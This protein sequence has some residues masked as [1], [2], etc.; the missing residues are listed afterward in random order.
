MG[1][2]HRI[3]ALG[4]GLI[5]V[6]ACSA[7]RGQTAAS[8]GGSTTAAPVGSP[9]SRQSSQ[10]FGTLASPCGPGHATGATDQGVTGTAIDIAYGDD[11]GF[12]GQPGLNKEM[13]DAVRGMIKWCNDQGGMLVRSSVT[14]TMPPSPR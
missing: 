1:E 6:A 4:V 14:S 5:L 8:S 2:R 7:S 11:R 3:V 9:A 13:G 12:A 10:R